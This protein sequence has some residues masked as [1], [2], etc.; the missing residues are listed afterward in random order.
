MTTPIAQGP[1]DV[2]VRPWFRCVKVGDMLNPDPLW[3]NT[4]RW[5][6]CLAVP[7]EVL[8]ITEAT[9]QSGVLF[10]VRT[11]GGFVRHLDAGWFKRPNSE[12]R[13][14]EKRSFDDSPGTTG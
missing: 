1:V 4:E 14:E 13:G 6:N 2:N 10:E 5:P 11:K 12:F 8:G 3:N 7:T 9:S